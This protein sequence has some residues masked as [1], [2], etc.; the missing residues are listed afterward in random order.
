MKEH[1][2]EQVIGALE[3]GRRFEFSSYYAGVR[4]VLEFDLADGR[5]V[6]A[7]YYAY[8]SGQDERRLFTREELAAHLREHFSYQSFNLP[9][10]A[11]PS[12][13]AGGRGPSL[14]LCLP[15]QA[16]TGPRSWRPWRR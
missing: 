8:E 2:A 4:E 10:A 16:P 12:A 9:P 6:L 7:T 15:H 1:E 11:G 3:T 14:S 5:F 13:P